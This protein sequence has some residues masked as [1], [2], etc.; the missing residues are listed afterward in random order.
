[1]SAFGK[2]A[3]LRTLA[4]EFLAPLLPVVVVPGSC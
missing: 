2:F 1:M 3:C 4:L